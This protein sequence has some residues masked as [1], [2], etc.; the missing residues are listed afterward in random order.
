MEVAPNVVLNVN[1]A[2]KDGSEHLIIF[3]HGFP[4]TGLLCWK[5]QIVHVS[6]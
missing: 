5:D 4:E 3:L 6:K 2:G 1:E